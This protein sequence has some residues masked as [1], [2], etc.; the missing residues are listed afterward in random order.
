MP[1]DI[2]V[3]PR[4]EIAREKWDEFVDASD[5]AWLW[6]RSDFIDALELWPGYSEASF[7]LV[8]GRDAILA[9]M[10]MHRTVV[11][12]AGVVPLARFSSLGGP[13]CAANMPASMRSNVLAA[14][15]EHLLQ[16][17]AERKVLAA[18]VQIAPL[19]PSLHGP[20]AAKVNP[21]ILAGFENTQTETWMVD[22]TRPAAEI[23]K[24]Y[25]ELTRRE[26]RKASQGE[27]RVREAAG[28]KDLDIYYR[29]HLET[30]GRTGAKP[31]PLE[32]FQAIFDKF[33]PRGL[34]R[35]LF[36]ERRGDVV[37]AQN[38]GR[39]KAGAVYWTGASDTVKEGGENRILFDAQIMAA[40]EDGFTRYE[41]GQAFVNS[42]NA[43]ETG[44]S[45][46]KR[47]FGADIYPYYRGVLQS[48]RSSFRILSGLR[49][50][51]QTMGKAGA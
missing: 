47:S 51:L 31:H 11:R 10:P 45:R 40:H 38:T 48:P 35:I 28:A 49:K 32:Y 29:L 39:Y 7:A 26:L 42:R 20:A 36:A 27:L 33:Q 4:A 13:A 43:K 41:T 9:A 18:E 15:H 12:A 14:L 3:R 1:A 21:L 34:A 6:H 23:R 19:T 30:Y 46:F 17:I 37:A 5:E 8:D 16:S 24:H 50:M 25:S 44:L 2:Q 22:L